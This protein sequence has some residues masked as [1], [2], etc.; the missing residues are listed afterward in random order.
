[1][2]SQDPPRCTCEPAAA[3]FSRRER[4]KLAR[5]GRTAVVL[6]APDCPVAKAQRRLIPV[7]W[8]YLR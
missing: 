3:V 5:T 4:R 2:V 1:M 8:W 7:T 6:H